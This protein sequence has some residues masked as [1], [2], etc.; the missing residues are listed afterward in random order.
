MTRRTPFWLVLGLVALL[1][2]G[3]AV[4]F[5]VLSQTGETPLH[6]SLDTQGDVIVAGRGEGSGAAGD[7]LDTGTLFRPG[8]VAPE[9]P[10]FVIAEMY[11]DLAT[12]RHPVWIGDGSGCEQPLADSP[13]PQYIPPTPT[14]EPAQSWAKHLYQQGACDAETGACP[15]PYLDEIRERL[16]T[17]TP[18]PGQVVPDPMPLP[19]INRATNPSTSQNGVRLVIAITPTRRKQCGRYSPSSAYGSAPPRWPTMIG[20]LGSCGTTRRRS[21]FGP[22]SAPRGRQR[23][24]E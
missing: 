3:L 8:H 12:A 1:I 9:R 24:S 7:G 21:R 15:T 23:E 18:D 10:E 2:L 17:P 19:W 4:G 5:I 13:V 6:V 20:R 14:P 16:I 22:P 11:Q